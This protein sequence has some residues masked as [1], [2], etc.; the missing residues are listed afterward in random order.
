MSAVPGRVLVVDDDGAIRRLVSAALRRQHYE[1][2]EA[3]N[4]QE[5]MEKL[6]ARAFDALLLDLMMPVRDGYEV[7]AFL[8][9]EQQVQWKCVVVMTAAGTRGTRDLDATLVH[10]VLH[11]PFDIGDVFIAVRA[12]IGS[13]GASPQTPLT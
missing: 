9:R 1:T 5:A 10:C 2:E 12:C 7:L 6:N 13:G 8:R 4:G 3:A 11:K